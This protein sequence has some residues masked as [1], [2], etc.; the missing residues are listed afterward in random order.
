MKQTK[1][2]NETDVIIPVGLASA[3]DSGKKVAD[4]ILDLHQ[5]Y[6]Y[7]RFMLAGP[8]KGWRAIGFPPIEHFEELAYA[9]L[10]AKNELLP[11]GIECGWWLTTVVKSG[12]CDDFVRIKRANGSLAPFSSCPL[13]EK[14]REHFAD[15]IARFAKIAK[16]AFIITEDDYSILASAPVNG[17]F[18]DLHLEEFSKRMG[19]EYT[20]EELS[21]ILSERTPEALEII[22]KWRELMKDTL[23]DFAKTIRKKLDVDSPEIPVGYM[24]SEN[25]DAEG[26]C[27]YDICKALA[28]DRHTPFSRLYGTFYNGVTVQDIPTVTFHAIYSRQH[29]E[30]D[31]TYYHESDSFPSSRFFTSGTEMRAIMATAYSAGFN[32]STFQQLETSDLP[33][34]T[35]YG[36]M[37]IKERGRFGEICKTASMCEMKGVEI[38]YD[39]FYNSLEHPFAPYWAQPIGLFG[40]PYTTKESPVAFWDKRQAKYSDDKTVKKYLS[41][42]LFLDGEAAKALCERGYSDYLGA[43]IG[44]EITNGPLAFDLG[45]KE[46]VRDEFVS[47]GYA[48]TMGIASIFASGKEGKAL[49]ITPNDPKTKII[50]DVVNSAKETICPGM[51][52]YKNELGGTVIVMGMMIAGSYSQSLLCY[53]RQRLF[54]KLISEC[55]DEFAFVKNSPRIFTIM[56]EAKNEKESGFIGMLTLINLGCDTE[57][58]ILLH[59]PENFAK[60]KSIFALKGDGKWKKVG[61]TR[62]KDGMSVNVSSNYLEPLCLLFK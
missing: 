5:K 47:E 10:E 52:L 26:D 49:R 28:G 12:P 6:G 3:I 60:A 29:I 11:Y 15:C 16:P 27:T 61:F 25:A 14:F 30:G 50:T 31:F 8:A 2:G 42:V 54:H 44:D 38:C 55:C 33:E 62:T 51:T 1:C 13:D 56:N 39:P 58:D 57:E 34:E 46:I 41:K 17:C 48:R 37:F 18:C 4:T 59:L 22:K 7:R 45:A 32:G 20:R 43:E 53:T 23:V 24:Q 35:A 36:K 40:I 19:T 9:F 21:A